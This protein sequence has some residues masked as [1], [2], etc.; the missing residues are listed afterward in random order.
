M[1]IIE[2]ANLLSINNFQSEYF[3]NAA[4]PLTF[5]LPG[6]DEK[7]EYTISIASLDT[8]GGDDFGAC[9]RLVKDTSS[10]NYKNSEV[11][12]SAEKKY[13]EM[14]ARDMRYILVKRGQ[15]NPPDGLR[16]D[17]QVSMEKEGFPKALKGEF[18]HTRGASD[19]GA[20][21]S[22]M[23]TYEDGYEVIYCYELH[24]KTELRSSGIGSRLMDLMEHVGRKVGVEKAILTVFRSNEGARRFYQKRG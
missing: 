23:L 3:S 5:T 13:R 20:F 22:F 21:L 2:K 11:G 10:R 24:V 18:R 15:G 14:R 8:M 1:G 16:E 17:L 7:E 6:Q 9:Y 12:W 4:I 19:V